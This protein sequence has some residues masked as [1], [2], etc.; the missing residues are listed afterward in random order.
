MSAVAGVRSRAVAVPAWLWLGGIVVA[1]VGVR[2]ALARRMVAP[3]IMVDELIYSELAKSFAAHGQFLVRD[4]PSHGYGFVYPVL[5]SPAWRVFSSVTDAYA[6]AKTINCVLMSLT[7]VPAYFLARRVVRPGLALLAATLAVAVPSLVY[8]GT[9]MTENAFYPLFTVCALLLVLVLERPT[10]V[11]IALLLLTCGLAF[12]TRAQAVALA[13]A[14][15]TA[16]LLL[17][18]SRW[19]EFRALYGVVAAGVVLVAAYELVRGRSP[20]D[21]LGAY[22]AATDTHYTVATVLRW[23]AYHVGELDLYLGVAPFAALLLLAGSRARARPF[24]AAATS[25]A[26]WVVLVVATFASAPSVSRIE[27]RNM[28]Y[29]APLFFTA[30]L[31]WI[32]LGCPRPRAA[33]GCALLAGAL[34]GVVPFTGLLNGNATS[35][36]LAFIP[37]W[38]LQDTVITLDEVG[39]VAVAGSIVVAALWLY[40]PARWALALPALL[41]ALYAFAVW[42][43]E[44]NPHGGIHHASQGALFGGTSLTD[45]E[46]IDHAVGAKGDVTVIY[47]SA[48][49][50]KFEAWTN[51][52]FNRRVGRVYDLHDPTP[53]GVV[54]RPTTIDPRTGVLRGVV[55]TRYVLSSLPLVGTPVADDPLK[56]LTLW[57]I[58]GA[59]RVASATTGVYADSWTAPVAIVTSFDCSGTT[60]LLLE[61]DNSLFPD[62]QRVTA[63]GREYVVRGRRTI[64]V[65][66]CRV[67]LTVTPTR[68]PGAGDTREL[69]IHL[70]VVR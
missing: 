7:A 9:L 19:R 46:W 30:L 47:D 31:L 13:P 37:F 65:P 64:V 58:A 66:S 69:G 70:H 5:I 24:V 61:Q 41:L 62:P 26:F 49:M 57:S 21:A 42:P 50:D 14:I 35:D 36:T 34:P 48:T 54:E 44:T 23:F 56:G 20:L 4:V 43:I 17:P 27:E 25:L 45:R 67:R 53:G 40:L 18:R 55:P 11:R 29:V 2:I 59:P 38:T 32:E 16:P 3:W 52:F 68:V 63:N 10:A 60:R 33:A 8:T 51:E 22:R 15:V 12:L 28:F 1:S 39:L 6:A